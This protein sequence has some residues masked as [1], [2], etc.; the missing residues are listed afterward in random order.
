MPL[1]I[2][3]KTSMCPV[4]D[5]VIYVDEKVKVS[6]IGQYIDREYFLVEE[7]HDNCSRWQAEIMHLNCKGKPLRKDGEH[8]TIAT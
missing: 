7:F 6:L 3:L 5:Q 4:C 1:K 8:A 2:R